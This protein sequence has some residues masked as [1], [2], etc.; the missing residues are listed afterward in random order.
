MLIPMC[1]PLSLPFCAPLAGPLAK[2]YI[3]LHLGGSQ[4]NVIGTFYA[5]GDSVAAVSPLATV[6]GGVLTT[7]TIN[8]KSI[9]D[10]GAEVLTLTYASTDYDI[11][12]T[13]T[14]SFTMT[15]VEPDPD[16][17]V[18]AANGFITITVDS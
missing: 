14:A 4:T 13:G 9:R 3:V 8:A 2:S 12:L 11:Y 17:T 5:G 1:V 7:C 18:S 10:A 6:V 16:F 15:G